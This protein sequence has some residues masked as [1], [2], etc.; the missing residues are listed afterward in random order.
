MA[1]YY[2]DIQKWIL[3]HLKDRPLALLRCPNGEGK[4]CFFQKHIDTDDEGIL[5]HSVFSKLKNKNEK[6]LSIDSMLGLL[7]LVQLGTIEIHT[8]G[9]LREKIDYP[10]QI[11]FD[12]D[13]D[14]GVSFEKVKNAALILKKLL[15]QLKLKSFVKTSGGKGLHVHVPIAPLYDW[16]QIK[17]FSKSICE[18]MEASHPD[19]FTTTISKAKRKGKIFLDYLR[20]S[21]GASAIAPYSVRAHPH[22]PVALPITWA[23]VKKLKSPNLHTI[24]D[25]PKLLKKRTDPWKGYNRLKQKITMLDKFNKQNK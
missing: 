4:E 8:R 13:P 24:L 18:Q 14:P 16:D 6:V 17:A 7:E 10:N 23:K 3:P 11:V 22:A 20:N 1:D 19:D 15:E 21:F 2:N 12:F 25:V 9:C 5:G